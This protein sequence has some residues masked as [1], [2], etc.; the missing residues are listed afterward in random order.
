MEIV[1]SPLSNIFHWFQN[2]T[3]IYCIENILL[4]YL[5]SVYENIDDEISQLI[6]FDNPK[7]HLTKEMTEV[8]YARLWF[9][10]LPPA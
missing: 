2:E 6:L 8:V 4:P 10:T 9:A 5:K 1:S 7:T 3:M